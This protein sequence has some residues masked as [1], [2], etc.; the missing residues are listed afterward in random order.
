MTLKPWLMC[1]TTLPDDCIEDDEDII[2]QPGR[3]VAEALCEVLAAIGCSKIGDPWEE[4][5]KGWQFLFVSEG[6]P[7]WC[8]VSRP[9]SQ[10]LVY[11]GKNYTFEGLFRA[12]PSRHEVFLKRLADGLARDD[13]FSNQRWYSHKEIGSVDYS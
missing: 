4:G 11:F 7:F 10:C 9:G 3:N 1:D 13:R 8:R 2:Q 6:K 12:G 5:P